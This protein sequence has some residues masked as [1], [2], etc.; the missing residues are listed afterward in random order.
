[1]RVPSGAN[2]SGP[3]GADDAVAE[4]GIDLLRLQQQ[5]IEAGVAA[6]EHGQVRRRA[7][8]GE[9]RILLA[10]DELRI[11]DVDHAIGGCARLEHGHRIAVLRDEHALGPRLRHAEVVVAGIEVVRRIGGLPLLGHHRFEVFR[12]LGAR[13][14]S[15]RARDIGGYLLVGG[16]AL[17][18]RWSCRRD[19]CR[20]AP[21]RGGGD[22]RR[23]EDL[24]RRRLRPSQQQARRGRKARPIDGCSSLAPHQALP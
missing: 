22:L 10:G 8:V 19:L 12:R 13:R 11:G 5:R 21:R 20:H 4:H 23:I 6:G 14:A 18:V 3:N 7:Q 2:G 1:M 24:R 16:N 9:R 15:L 17:I